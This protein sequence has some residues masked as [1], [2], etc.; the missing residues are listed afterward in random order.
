[1]GGKDYAQ[2]QRISDMVLTVLEFNYGDEQVPSVEE[3]QD[4]VEKVLIKNGHA[5]TRKAFIL[6]REQHRK[7][8][9]TRDMASYINGT[10]DGYLR[11]SD[12]RVQENSNSGY[13]LSGLLMHGAG[14]VV[15][16]YTLIMLSF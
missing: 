10:M 7:M 11:Q 6:Y 14:S 13:S 12:W 2:A 9:E 15:R 1:V 8:R 3:V 16:N 4:V 5:K